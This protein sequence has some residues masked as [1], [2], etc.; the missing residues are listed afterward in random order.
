MGLDINDFPS[1]FLY[2]FLEVS[3]NTHTHTQPNN[4]P[5]LHVFR[6]V[7]EREEHD[8]RTKQVIHRT[9]RQK[10]EELHSPSYFLLI[11]FSDSLFLFTQTMRSN[12][13]T[14]QRPLSSLPRHPTHSSPSRSNLALHSI[15]HHPPSLPPSTFTLFNPKSGRPS[16][17]SSLLTMI[18]NPSLPPS[19]Q[20]KGP[21]HLRRSRTPVPL[22]TT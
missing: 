20:P 6:R 15:I 13:L 10:N 2:L 14:A 9:N 21:P 1:P 7:Q 4:P 8:E 5:T 3:N 12:L 22:G 11:I 18:H 19:L 16:S 17:L